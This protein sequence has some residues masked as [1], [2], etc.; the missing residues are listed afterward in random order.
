MGITTIADLA[1]ADPVQIRK[2]FNVVVMRIALELRGIP[3]ITA[4]EDRTGKK[5]QLI[6]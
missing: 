6:V 4:E 3:S 1:A 5:E 2:A